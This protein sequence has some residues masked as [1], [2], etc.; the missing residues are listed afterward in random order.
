MLVLGFLWSWSVVSVFFGVTVGGAAL[1]AI[2]GDDF[3]L[4]GFLFAIGIFVVTVRTLTWDVLAS[5]K[6]RLWASLFTVF[7]GASCF[8][9]CEYWVHYK[10]EEHLRNSTATPDQTP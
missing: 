7:L 3:T 1:A 5:H 8:A 10:A 4:A 2:Y 6:D 9:G